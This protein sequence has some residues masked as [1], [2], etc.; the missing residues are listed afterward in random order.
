MSHQP[1]NQQNKGVVS[2]KADSLVFIFCFVKDIFKL[3]V[4]CKFPPSR[5]TLPSKIFFSCFR[6]MFFNKASNV[7]Q[8][9]GV[10]CGV[11]FSL[12]KSSDFDVWFNP[13]NQLKTK[14]SFFEVR[15]IFLITCWPL[16]Q[17]KGSFI[18]QHVIGK[19]SGPVFESSAKHFEEFSFSIWTALATAPTVQN[20]SHWG[21]VYTGK[22]HMV[23]SLPHRQEAFKVC[24]KCPGFYLKCQKQQHK[25]E[26]F[27]FD[28][29]IHS[30]VL[31]FSKQKSDR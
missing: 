10:S 12:K 24:C 26:R 18:L 31:S 20:F 23:L 6:Q 19:A 13:T 21:K 16:C 3:H 9:I 7:F 25:V 2:V 29:D 14:P 28:L 22:R 8:F 15:S 4:L 11:L 5:S 30:V 17:N 27:V 1:V